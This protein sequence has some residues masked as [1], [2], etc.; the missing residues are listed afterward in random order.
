M[1]IVE[2]CKF[3]V[4]RRKWVTWHECS[5]VIGHYHNY[6]NLVHGT[7]ITLWWNCSTARTIAFDFCLL[8]NQYW[9]FISHR[10]IYCFWGHLYQAYESFRLTNLA[11]IISSFRRTRYLFWCHKS[12]ENSF[13]PKVVFNLTEIWN[14]IDDFVNTFLDR[15]SEQSATREFPSFKRLTSNFYF[16]SIT[17]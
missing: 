3:T 4:I 10:I 14:L 9:Y 1:K 5:S 6:H 17:I 15:F 7:A 2:L 16:I 8:G 13:H 12:C 11:N